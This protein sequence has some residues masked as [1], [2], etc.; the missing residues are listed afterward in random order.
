MGKRDGDEAA[1]PL[2]WLPHQQRF[3]RARE[4]N[5][6]LIT[7]VGAG[8]SFVG[9]WRIAQIAREE[10]PAYVLIATGSRDQLLRN[11]V[12]P[13]QMNEDLLGFK[14]EYK[15]YPHFRVT[16]TWPAGEEGQDPPVGRAYAFAVQTAR[17]L[18][19][20]RGLS[21]AAAWLDEGRD[22]PEEA[23]RV[24]KSRVRVG[25]GRRQ[26]LLTST[27]GEGRDWMYRYFLE[28][29]AKR[30]QLRKDRLLIGG[31]SSADNPH[32]PQDYLDDLRDSYDPTVLAREFK[33][34]WVT[35]KTLSAYHQFDRA[36]HVKRGAPVAY[37]PELPVLFTMDFNILGSALLC[38]WFDEHFWVFDEIQ[39]PRSNTWEVVGEAVRRLW[40]DKKPAQ[41]V[42][43]IVTAGDATGNHGDTRS[44]YNDWQ[45]IREILRNKAVGNWDY[46]EM[47]WR[48]NPSVRD[49]LV[50]L[51]GKLHRGE[52]LIHQRCEK[53]ILDLEQTNFRPG[54]ETIDKS[55]PDRT[56]LADALRYGVKAVY[57]DD[58]R[59][60]GA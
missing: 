5:V 55:D 7:G 18:N 42:R 57:F 54:T 22:L 56:H 1:P 29:P 31:V 32:N 17:G 36:V 24:V 43:K 28:A 37:R 16:W 49:T 14:T 19:R 2:T 9:A 11:I 10:Y 27:P 26:L 25:K 40:Y 35:D 4:K 21:V 12:E 45:I 15:G 23:W 53:L 60:P 50:L 30:P 44:R 58:P 51:N 6:A 59:R 8:K 20:M 46:G 52:V 47:S 13:M 38:H 33:G 48:S 39:M 3:L 41:R 34:Q